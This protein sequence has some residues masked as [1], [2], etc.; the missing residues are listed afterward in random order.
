MV[1]KTDKPLARLSDKKGGKALIKPEMKEKKQQ[2]SQKYR[3][4]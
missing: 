3:K 4:I 2:I 1:N